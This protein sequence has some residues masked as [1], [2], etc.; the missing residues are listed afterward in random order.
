MPAMKINISVDDISPRPGSDTKCLENCFRVLEHFPNAKYTLFIPTAIQR[1][2]DGDIFPYPI[3]DYPD[4][5]KEIRSLSPSNFE[6]GYHGVL[7]GRTSPDI[8][9]NGEFEFLTYIEA[10]SKFQLSK[11]MFDDAEIFVKPIFRPSAFRMSPESFD[12]SKDFGIKMLALIDKE[13]YKSIY[14][15]KDK[16]FRKVSYIDFNPPYR[17]LDLNYCTDCDSIEIMYHALQKDRNYF[18][19]QKADDLIM[20]LNEISSVEFVFMN[21]LE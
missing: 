11:Q 9:N 16:N 2:A 20:F 1:F 17:E 12:A 19:E 5:M 10:F 3:T 14:S 6:I 21:E 7:H 8:N 4:F 18:D 15:G 13:P